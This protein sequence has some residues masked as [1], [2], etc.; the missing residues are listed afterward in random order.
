[1]RGDETAAEHPGAGVGSSAQHLLQ[2]PR[3]E[4][5]LSTRDTDGWQTPEEDPGEPAEAQRRGTVLMAAFMS[6]WGLQGSMSVPEGRGEHSALRLAACGWE[7]G[8]GREG[9]NRLQAPAGF[10]HLCSHCL[11]CRLP[12]PPSCRTRPRLA[13]PSLGTHCPGWHS[14]DRCAP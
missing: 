13:T 8:R 10:L 7:S 1:M 6:H 9:R 4:I 3:A 2:G 12:S 11:Q 14:A 5:A